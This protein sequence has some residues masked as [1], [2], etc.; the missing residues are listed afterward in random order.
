MPLAKPN[1]NVHTF[2]ETRQA[3]M[4]VKAA[5]D[6]S[7]GLF[8]AKGQLLTASAADEPMVLSVG[9]NDTVLT[10]DSAETSGIKWAFPVRGEFHMPFF[11]SAVPVA[12]T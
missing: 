5:L 11:A 7:V 10:A 8:Q 12:I 4:R 1:P 3:L 9:A 2:D 6:K